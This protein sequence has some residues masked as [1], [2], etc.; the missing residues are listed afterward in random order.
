MNLQHD[1]LVSPPSWNPSF[2]VYLQSR[3]ET[4]VN[5]DREPLKY[6]TE[7]VLKGYWTVETVSNYLTTGPH[8]HI[9]QSAEVIIES[10]IRVWSTL[11]FI[12]RP[13]FISWFRRKTRHDESFYDYG[14]TESTED[15]PVLQDT[16][17]IFS[18]HWAMFWPVRFQSPPNSM[19]Q[20]ELDSR[21]VLPVTFSRQ[22]SQQSSLSSSIIHEVDLERSCCD[23]SNVSC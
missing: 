13:Q 11:V 1:D 12:G 4:G 6:V 7:D 9:A 5:I 21:R 22:L 20:T 15:D 23:Y 19:H 2:V 16:L 17:K 14:F 3:W 8:N 18:E 10:Y